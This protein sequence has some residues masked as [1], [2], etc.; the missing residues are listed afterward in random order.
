MKAAIYVRVSTEEQATEGMSVSGQIETLTQYCNLFGLEIYSIYKDLGIS[1]KDTINRPG[2]NQL[3]EDSTKGLFNSVLVWKISRLSR[4]LKDLLNIVDMFDKSGVSFI[5]YS[6]KFDTSTPVGKMTLQLLGSIAEFERNT[7]IE[8]VKMGLKERIRQ[9]NKSGGHI[10][11]YDWKDKKLIINDHE[12]DAVRTIFDL[13]VN[14]EYSL[15]AITKYLN[16]SGYKT[17]RDIRFT[18]FSVGVILKNPTY[19]GLVR[20]N[21]NTENEY[22]VQGNHSPLISEEIYNAAQSRRSTR[23]TLT[24]RNHEEGTFLLTGL[25]K[26][27]LCNSPLCG[28]YNTANKTSA[29]GKNYNYRYRY[30]KCNRETA[31]HDCKLGYISADKLENKAIAIIL[32]LAENTNLIEDSITKTNK[33]AE[34][35][36]APIEKQLK[37]IES[38]LVK[39]EKTKNSYFEMF[40]SEEINDKKIFLERLNKIESEIQSLSSKRTELA[41][42]VEMHRSNPIALEKALFTIDAFVK[43]IQVA[44]IEDKKRLIRTIVQEIKITNDKDIEYIKLWLDNESGKALTFSQS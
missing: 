15:H 6:E 10:Y 5:S 40:E 24:Q 4:S 43:L 29:A 39:L 37:H 11:G 2:L 33:E 8:N 13:Y 21:T 31:K 32:G 9:G 7:I 27:P 17:K 18:H 22:T 30:Y 38:Q 3:I 28:T 16:D 36:L 41:R 26:C 42:E 1:G 12:A 44:S 19:I 25:I 14:K 20:H 35:D 34:K 23:S